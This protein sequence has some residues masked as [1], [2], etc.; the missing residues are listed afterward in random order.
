MQR[1]FLS[2]LGQSILLV[3]GVIILVFFMVRVTGDPA[4][5]MM[6][7]E[8]SAED[9]EAFREHMGFNRPLIVQFWD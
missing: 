5:L 2:K 9:M 6:P 3:L 7:R 8:A 4:R 1:Y